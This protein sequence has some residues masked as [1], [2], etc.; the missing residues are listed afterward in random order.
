[1]LFPVI[2]FDD[3]FYRYNREKGIIEYIG[4][5]NNLLHSIIIN[6]NDIR[7]SDFLDYYYNNYWGKSKRVTY[8]NDGS[9]EPWS[10][11]ELDRLN[12]PQYYYR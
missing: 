3:T 1:M 11:I 10:N 4:D 6:L 9:F 7:Y 2:N 8:V 5:Y 12:V